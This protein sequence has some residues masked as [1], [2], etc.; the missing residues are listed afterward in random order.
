MLE[1]GAFFDA[2][3]RA[4]RNNVRVT[5]LDIFLIVVCTSRRATDTDDAVELYCR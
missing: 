4:S 1:T 5:F 3:F 2:L